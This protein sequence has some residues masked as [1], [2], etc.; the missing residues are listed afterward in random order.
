MTTIEDF[1]VLAPGTGALS[2]LVRKSD[3]IRVE[4]T[5]SETTVVCA[6]TDGTGIDCFDTATPL[7]DIIA[8]LTPTAPEGK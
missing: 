3:V 5:D 6:N 2:L 7:A 4:S 8:Q 1:L